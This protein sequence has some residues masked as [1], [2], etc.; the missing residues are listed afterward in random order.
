[1]RAPNRDLGARVKV[2]LVQLPN[3][4]VVTVPTGITRKEDLFSVL[5]SQLSFP[6]YFGKNWDALADC[7]EDLEWISQH[8]VV[9]QHQDLLDALPA[10]DR[11]TYLSVLHLALEWWTDHHDHDLVVLFPG[12]Q[13]LDISAPSAD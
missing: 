1:M 2:E 5:A 7:I 9:L 10:N 11:K 4:L 8:T 3:S 13:I 12:P 6:E